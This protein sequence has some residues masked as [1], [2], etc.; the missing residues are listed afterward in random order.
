MFRHFHDIFS[1][2]KYLPKIYERDWKCFINNAQLTDSIFYHIQYGIYMHNLYN[3]FCRCQ[4]LLS[5]QSKVSLPIWISKKLVGFINMNHGSSKWSQPSRHTCK[6]SFYAWAYLWDT[7]ILIL[8]P[9][10]V[11][12]IDSHYGLFVGVEGLWFVRMGRWW[13]RYD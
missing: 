13:G 4:I 2:P 10:G 11:E 9:L 12:C 5:N 8:I 6:H 3:F 1:L 7:E